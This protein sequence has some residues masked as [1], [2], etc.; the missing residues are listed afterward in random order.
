M[1]CLNQRS[2][3]ILKPTSDR[4]VSYLENEIMTLLKASL[5]GARRDWS[6]A[7][8]ALRHRARV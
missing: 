1:L 8:L 5:C 4:A 7:S 2:N 3:Q 6:S